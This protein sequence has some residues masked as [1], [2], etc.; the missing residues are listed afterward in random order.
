[1]KKT[2]KLTYKDAGVDVYLGDECSKIMYDA[3]KKTWKNR[4]GRIGDVKAEYDDFSGLRFMKLI[5]NIFVGM[6][7]DGVGTK[8]EIAERL[9]TL[10]GCFD[11]HKNIAFD[12]F[13]MVCDDAA[14]RGAEPVAVGSILDVNKLNKNLIEKLAEGMIEASKEADVVV[15]N[16]EI[17]E[18]GERIGG[19]GEYRY[20]WGA[21]VFWVGNKKGLITGKQTTLGDKLVGF[22]EY[23]F[24]SNGFSLLRKIFIETFG[25]NWHK[26]YKHGKN[27]AEWAL[28]PSKIYSRAV[29]DMI[30]NLNSRNVR[31]K[32]IAHITGGGLA[33]K[34]KRLLKPLHLG[35]EIT[36][37]FEP[38]RLMLYSQEW[39][40]VD[41]K[42]AYRTWNMG[43]GMVVITNE[44]EAVIDIAK[45]YGIDAKIIGEIKKGTEIRIFSKGRF[46]E[47]KELVF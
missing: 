12:L 8:I 15:I 22:K 1:M 33:G 32:A 27:I 42:E 40:N 29:V 9:S 26:K 5:E 20:N 18:L 24:R 17:A 38:C 43:N 35:A 36:E 11:A 25:N 14:S 23:G 34:L 6:N 44:P 16:G 47:G 30:K 10:R 19:F 13:A 2:K 7:F 3:C 28:I 31:I 4:S 21:C 37:P 39:G 45:G 46:F 41:D